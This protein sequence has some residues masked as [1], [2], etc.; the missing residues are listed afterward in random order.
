MNESRDVEINTDTTRNIINTSTNLDTNAQSSPNNVETLTIKPKVPP[1]KFE[2]YI[3]NAYKKLVGFTEN[4]QAP[5][6][7]EKKAEKIQLEEQEKLNVN[8]CETE[9]RRAL[10]E[11]GKKIEYIKLMD[12]LVMEELKE[13]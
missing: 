3:M 13:I 4:K 6:K 7:Q 5:V 12:G 10:E 9:L 11:I 8:N 2:M 1:S